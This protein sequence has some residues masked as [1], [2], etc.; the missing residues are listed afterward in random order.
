M[1]TKIE[2]YETFTVEDVTTDEKGKLIVN[3]GKYKV[4]PKRSNLFNVFQ[5]GAEV[6]IGWANYM[7]QDYISTAEQTGNHFPTDAEAQKAFKEA[8][9]QLPKPQSEPVQSKSTPIVPSGQEVGMTT[10]EI[11]DMIRSKMLSV[12]FGEDAIKLTE[13]YKKRIKTTTGI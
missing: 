6:K 3:G 2:K 12:V 7:N 5:V 1:D 9:A 4:S 10:K 11:G 8:V 13:W